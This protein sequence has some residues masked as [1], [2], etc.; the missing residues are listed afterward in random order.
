MRQWCTALLARGSARLM[1]DG[2]LNED[3]NLRLI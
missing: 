1:A 2:P 3:E